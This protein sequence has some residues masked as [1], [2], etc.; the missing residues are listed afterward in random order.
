MPNYINF[1]HANFVQVAPSYH[2]MQNEQAKA[3]LLA[4]KQQIDAALVALQS[5]SSSNAY[6][7]L[8]RLMANY[9]EE[10]LQAL[11]DIEL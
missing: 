8:T 11:A 2:A 7:V 3:H 10:E 4:A 1:N 5:Q 6:E 9:S